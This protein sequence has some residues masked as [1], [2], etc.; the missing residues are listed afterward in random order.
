MAEI[1]LSATAKIPASTT[2]LGPGFDVLGIGLSLY[3]QVI[4]EEKASETKIICLGKDS[5]KI[6]ITPD[7]IAYQAVMKIF[8]HFDYHPPGI[9]L[10]INNGIPAIRGLGGSGTAILGGLL[11]AN[12]ICH[13]RLGTESLSNSEILSFATEFEGHPDNVAASLFG[14]VVVSAMEHSNKDR[15]PSI[16]SIKLLPPSDLRLIIAIPDFTL[17]TQK[18]RNILPNSV[19]FSD[20]VFNIGRSSLLVAALATGNLDLLATAMQDQLHQPYRAKLIPGF[21]EVIE[22]AMSAGALSVSLSGAGPTMIAYA[23]SSSNT[24]EISEKMAYAFKNNGL[25]S[26]TQILCVDTNGAEVGSPSIKSSR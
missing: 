2:N 13:K 12:L 23:R 15:L 9:R 21:N 14:G 10:T 22:A 25:S 20:A 5:E 18:A 6:P 24:N 3:S 16:K 7:N 4:L 11:T 26:Q 8:D 19:N 17:P 1:Y